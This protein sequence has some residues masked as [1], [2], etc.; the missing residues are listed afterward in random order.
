MEISA[1]LVLL[2][3]GGAL[4]AM[5]GFA[6]KFLHV[7]EDERIGKVTEMLPGANCGGCGYPGC[8]GLAQAMVDGVS[9]K[10]KDCKVIKSDKADELQAYLDNMNK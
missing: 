9:T 8:S 7:E 3:V 5:L 10:A 1:V 6:N 2:A 4:G